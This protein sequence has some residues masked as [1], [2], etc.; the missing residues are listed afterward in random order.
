MRLKRH[1]LLLRKRQRRSGCLPAVPYPSCR[2]ARVAYFTGQNAHFYSF[3]ENFSYVALA[4]F[5]V[6]DYSESLVEL[7]VAWKSCCNGLTE[8]RCKPTKNNRGV[9]LFDNIKLQNLNPRHLSL[10]PF[11]LPMS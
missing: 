2:Y 9:L 5:Y 4:D 11:L 10:E 3:S 1:P 6:A 8:S 7:D